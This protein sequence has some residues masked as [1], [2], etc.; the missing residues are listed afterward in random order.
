ME[1][2][3]N[4]NSNTQT[5]PKNSE[6]IVILGTGFIAGYLNKGL[7]QLFLSQRQSMEGNV[8]AIGKHPE[9]LA[10]R[11][12]ILKDCILCTDPIKDVLLR[13]HPTIIMIAVPPTVAATVAKETLLPY[14]NE[15]R[16]TSK[17]LPDL[18]SF[19]PTPDEYWYA[20]LL[21]NDIPIVKILP[22]IF[23]DVHGIDITSVGINTIS[24]TPAFEASDH[25]FLLSTILSP[26]GKTVSLSASEA[27]IFLSGKITSHVCC[28]ASFC[29][30]KATQKAGLSLSLND[31][32]KGFQY[33]QR[34]FTTLFE[35]P[36]PALR[37]CD[38]LPASLQQFIQ[39]FSDAWFDGLHDFTRSMPVCVPDEEA[40]FLD[41]CSYALN[42]IGI[43]VKTKSELEQDTKNA[44]TKG[45]V[46][47]RGIE[48]F[49]EVI[50]Q[51]LFKQAFLTAS[52]DSILPDYWE[53]LRSQA[54]NLSLEAF[55][56]SKTL[57]SH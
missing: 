17:S 50:E 57:T 29:I 36:I 53:K 41:V 4:I 16:A 11:S 52:G 56:R 46:L 26:Y 49:H 44:A 22:N 28:E 25:R 1:S 38:Q 2:A 27:L 3:K 20:N 14:Y 18:Y 21:G 48:Y 33:A 19:T 10:A 43:A 37:Q 54:Y 51:D 12:K 15:L 31:I 23:T 30:Q 35:D 13:F 8:C 24:P 9:K 5:S 7:H 34:K 47:E 45:G 55:K 39:N 40:L 6:K 42:T 32:G